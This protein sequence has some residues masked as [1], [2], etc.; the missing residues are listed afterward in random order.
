MP[1]EPDTVSGERTSEKDRETDELESETDA[2]TDDRTGKRRRNKRQWAEGFVR[3][4]RLEQ[5]AG[6]RTPS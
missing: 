4:S 5:P 2:L 6:S 1:A 3:L